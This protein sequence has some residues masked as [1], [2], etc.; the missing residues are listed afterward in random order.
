MDI[1][2]DSL[3]KS[4]GSIGGCV[5]ASEE[6]INYLKHFSTNYIF[7]T[8]LP[9]SVCATLLA[10]IQVVRQEPQL[11]AKLWENATQMRK[12]LKDLGFDIGTS[13]THIISIPIGDEKKTY[14][15]TSLLQ[16]SGVFVTP[17][18]R[19]AVKRGDSRVRITITANHST[20]DLEMSLYAL[21]LAGRKLGVF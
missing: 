8:S 5:A 6:V 4:L 7:T 10:S 15:F 19:P 1:L 9:P 16:E 21:G 17:V 14:E 18:V 2:T 20:A 12:G 11:R 3:G 13:M